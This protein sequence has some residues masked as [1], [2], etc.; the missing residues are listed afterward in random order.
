M[1]RASSLSKRVNTSILCEGVAYYMGGRNVGL[2][3][4]I[5]SHEVCPWHWADQDPGFCVYGSEL[6]TGT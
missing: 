1:M 5:F 4:E 2:I 6:N 3:S